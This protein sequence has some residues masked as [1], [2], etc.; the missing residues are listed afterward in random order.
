M[1]VACSQCGEMFEESDIVT[2]KGLPVCATCK[3]FFLKKIQEGD[4]SVAGF[5]YKGFWARLIADWFDGFILG[6]IFQAINLFITVP[7]AKST[8]DPFHFLSVFSVSFSLFFSINIA[9]YVFFNG[10][11]GATPGKMLIKAK[12]VNTD[13]TPISYTKALGRFF[14]EI[15]SAFTFGIGYIM[16]AFDSEKRALHD[17][18]C[19]TRVIKK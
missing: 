9:F 8:S 10:R 1:S 12:I 19:E 2:I 16:A 6:I 3:P 18:I 15:L 13:G 7:T 11:Y 4:T 14:A 17:R 5:V